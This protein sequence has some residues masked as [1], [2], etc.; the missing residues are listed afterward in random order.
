MNFRSAYKYCIFEHYKNTSFLCLQLSS[1][2]RSGFDDPLWFKLRLQQLLAFLQSSQVVDFSLE[3]VLFAVSLALENFHKLGTEFPDNF[4]I[5]AQHQMSF[6]TA[7]SKNALGN[8]EKVEDSL[9]SRPQECVDE[10]HLDAVASM[11]REIFR[12]ILFGQIAETL[13]FG[14]GVTFKQLLE[15]LSTALHI[16]L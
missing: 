12:T 6:G 16:L 2:C 10:V 13:G 15:V 5:S 1:I 14:G 3:I 7:A 8:S 9:R 11:E 4:W